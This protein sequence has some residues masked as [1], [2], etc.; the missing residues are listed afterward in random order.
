M[1]FDMETFTTQALYTALTTEIKEHRAA[2]KKAE[3]IIKNSVAQKRQA[4]LEGKT[5]KEMWEGLK[6][7]F[8]H[9]SPMTIS[10]LLLDTTRIQLSECSNMHEYG[11]KYQEAYDAICNMIPGDCELSAKGAATILQAGLLTGMGD[12]YSSLVS[13]MG[14]EWVSGKTDLTSS[15]LRLTRFAEIRKENAKTG[16]PAQA[17]ALLT[18]QPA[19]KTGGNRAPPGTCTFPDCIKKALTTDYPDRCFLKFPELRS[20]L[21]AKC[22]LQQMK[23]KGSNPNLRKNDP[24]TEDKVRES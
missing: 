18:A 15:I 20:E 4:Q 24:N 23:P 6:A 1:G 22:T 8:Q 2:L 14:S 3:G 13:S 5:A 10:R 7:K 19:P 17:S 9:I 16:G 21:R 12:E 11:S